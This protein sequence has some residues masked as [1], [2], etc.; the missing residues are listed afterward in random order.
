MRE[1]FLAKINIRMQ[2]NMIGYKMRS[3]Y[4]TDA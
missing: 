2:T 3:L 4:S 1:R